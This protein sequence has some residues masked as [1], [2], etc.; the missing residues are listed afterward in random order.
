MVMGER[1][2][3]R[4]IGDTDRLHSASD[5]ALNES[6]LSDWEGSQSD[7]APRRG[8]QRGLALLAGSL[9]VLGL[10][11][12]AAG[13]CIGLLQRFGTSE[14]LSLSLTRA[15][16]RSMLGTGTQGL[17]VT[18]PHCSPDTG[19]FLFKR[20]PLSEHAAQVAARQLLM[21]TKGQLLECDPPVGLEIGGR[22]SFTKDHMLRAAWK[23]SRDCK[24]ITFRLKVKLRGEEQKLWSGQVN[25]NLES[26]HWNLLVDTF[27]PPLC[28]IR[29]AAENSPGRVP[30]P[31]QDQEV[32]EAAEF[33]VAQINFLRAQA[34]CGAGVN[35][36]LAMVKRAS[37]QLSEDVSILLELELKVTERLGLPPARDLRD[38]HTWHGLVQQGTPSMSR[39]ERALVTVF[40]RYT[41]E[42]APMQL[43]TGIW[44]RHNFSVCADPSTWAPPRISV[45]RGLGDVDDEAADAT[46]RVTVAKAYWNSSR[47]LLENPPGVKPPVTLRHIEVGSLPA[48]YDARTDGHAR[49]CM[50][51][52]PVYDQGSC[53]CCY[54]AAMAQMFSLRLCMRR[55][56]EARARVL[57][58]PARRL[59]AEPGCVDDP[60]WRDPEGRSCGA[61]ASDHGHLCSQADVG[62]L[63]YCRLAC[64]TCPNTVADLDAPGLKQQYAYA[65][66]DVA[67]CACNDY[68]P[69]STN[70]ATN[71]RAQAGC[72]GGSMWAVWD[73]WLRLASRRLRKRDCMPLSIKCLNSQGVTNPLSSGQCRA[74]SKLNPFDRPCSC[75][76][77]HHIPAQL[78]RCHLHEDSC[79]EL[80]APEM[81]FQLS[82]ASHGLTPQATVLNMQRH[83]LEAGPIYVA[84]SVSNVFMSFWSSGAG[85]RGDV[86]AGDDDPDVGGH[87][88]IIVGWGLTTPQRP[89]GVAPNSL[90]WI[91]RNSWTDRWAE[92]GYGKIL[93][94]KNVKGIEE[95]TAAA[96]MGPYADHSAPVCEWKR[97]SFPYMSYPDQLCRMEMSLV[98]QCS[99]EATMRIFWARATDSEEPDEEDFKGYNAPDYRCPALSDCAVSGFDLL[100]AGYGLQDATLYLKIKA[101]D[102]GGHAYSSSSSIPIGAIPGM[103]SVGGQR[104]CGVPEFACKG[105]VSDAWPLPAKPPPT[106]QPSPPW[107]APAE[108]GQHPWNPLEP[109]P[110]AP[111]SLTDGSSRR[112][113][114]LRE[115]DLPSADERRG[116]ALAAHNAAAFCFPP[117]AAVSLSGGTERAAG[118]L[119]P[120][121]RLLL[122][123]NGASAYL[124]DFHA[125][126]P[127]RGYAPMRYLRV[128][129]ALQRPDRPLLVSAKHLV[130]VAT[131]DG[132]GRRAMPAA[133]IRPGQ[134]ALLILPPS[135]GGGGAL[136]LSRVT[137][138]SEEVLLPG[139]A[140]PLAEVGEL[141]VEGVLVSSYALLS[142]AQ[143]HLWRRGPWLLRDYL[144]EICHFL[145]LPYRAAS[146][147]RGLMSWFAPVRGA[148]NQEKLLANGALGGLDAYL[149]VLS[150]AFDCVSC[151]LV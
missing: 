151:A 135:A 115:L 142:E 85:I 126:R 17:P 73:A 72:N 7:E 116:E 118:A 40:V 146:T 107:R 130:F 80:P 26:H 64:S 88:V 149:R 87:A 119:R 92:G 117:S 113:S 35:I 16:S 75:I 51:G 110:P 123:G 122:P 45:A 67:T 138:V 83:I 78:P 4:R 76:P 10:C 120:G 148:G 12:V 66:Q 106:P 82:S 19:P 108:E 15:P 89:L 112:R 68:D 60:T 31:N 30:M 27:R 48:E 41:E 97:S 86:Y 102:S 125:G 57:A 109:E 127:D 69:T 101:W 20:V 49:G 1:R 18:A 62:Q 77:S 23:Y 91:F 59:A 90:Y 47:R 143:L 6:V 132:G 61:Y 98:I 84:F 28:Q 21:L 37:E 5:D 100:F 13:A 14:G 136:Q 25:W 34:H 8:C 139:Y 46:N 44:G 29:S 141:F 43:A 134:H 55:E 103:V 38:R 140:A 94:G 39:L 79:A 2:E 124:Q 3:Y 114:S 33:A 104:Q 50:E 150:H 11:L 63:S 95:R 96:M 36:T 42:P 70:V 129:H 99:E 74:Y 128:E 22:A 93:A 24:S 81:L 145:A 131:A 32:L 133:E 54:G 121:D 9:L 105:C 111:P 71:C 52:I 147:L 65:T 137:A 58:Q 56:R 53:G 144:Q